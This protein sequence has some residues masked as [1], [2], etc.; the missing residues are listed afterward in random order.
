V[1]RIITCQRPDGRSNEH[2]EKGNASS[3][4]SLFFHFAHHAVAL[5]QVDVKMAEL[6]AVELD[7][8]IYKLKSMI[9]SLVLGMGGQSSEL[10]T[11]VN[12]SRG[13]WPPPNAEANMMEAAL[14]MAASVKELVNSSKT[15]ILEYQEVGFSSSCS[16]FKMN[17]ETFSSFFLP[18]GLEKSCSLTEEA[19]KRLGEEVTSKCQNREI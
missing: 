4:L 19:Q 16:L 18:P 1:R 9:H 15:A 17:W 5:L 6:H 3:S 14:A 7:S 8:S 10:L 12:L 13:V 11:R 2:C